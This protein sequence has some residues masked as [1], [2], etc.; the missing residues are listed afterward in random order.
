M[1]TPVPDPTTAPDG[2][3]SRD[4]QQV[5]L[6]ATGITLDYVTAGEPAGPTVLLIMGMNGQRILWPTELAEA[7]VEAGCHV[8]AYDNR[9]VGRSTVLD[10]EHVDLETVTAAMN[11]HPFAAPYGLADMAVD[12]VGLLDHLGIERAHVVGV[13]MG[14][15]IA[16]HLAIDHPERVAS[17]TSINSTTGMAPSSAPR[18]PMVPIPDPTPPTGEAE[19]VEWF[20][21][22]LAELSSAHHFDEADTRELARA[23]HDRGVH[24]AGGLRH[25]LA[26][27]ADGDRTERLAGVRVPTLVI[28]GADDPL[29]DVEAGRATAAAIPGARL[30]ILEEMAHDLPLALVPQVAGAVLDH[31]T[32]AERR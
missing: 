26:I 17:L 2:S 10:D 6:P 1:S 7:L 14:G 24:P 28:H 29:V 11:G 9:D 19:F 18:E 22:G 31:I 13:S 3:W 23:V 30:L 15:M 12:A 8:V 27:L 21:S 16:Q 20:T 25:L 32:A 4:G 5:R